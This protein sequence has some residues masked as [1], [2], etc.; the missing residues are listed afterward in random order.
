MAHHQLRTMRA[1]KS[2]LKVVIIKVAVEADVYLIQKDA[3]QDHLKWYNDEKMLFSFSLNS[4]FYN[5]LAKMH[6]ANYCGSISK[7]SLI[8]LTMISRLYCLP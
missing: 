8:F 3:D 6:H 1:A 4:D 5:I 7:T 2:K